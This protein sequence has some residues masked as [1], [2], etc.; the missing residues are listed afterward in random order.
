VE[1]VNDITSELRLLL[2]SSALPPVERLRVLLTAGEILQRQ[3][4]EVGSCGGPVSA[5]SALGV[6]RTALLT[7]CLQGDIMPA[8][9]ADFCTELYAALQ[10]SGLVP[11]FETASGPEEEDE[12]FASMTKLEEQGA[13]AGEQVS[14]DTLCSLPALAV[15][16]YAVAR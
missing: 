8:E 2:R 13:K 6:P 1:Y 14:G 3:E 9:R 15:C 5:L 4:K 10:H 12:Q 16:R 7:H 11:L